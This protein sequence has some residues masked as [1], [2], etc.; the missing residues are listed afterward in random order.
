MPP[1]S[2]MAGLLGAETV[3]T[4]LDHWQTVR[5]ISFADHK[6][7]EYQIW[8]GLFGALCPIP[9]SLSCAVEVGPGPYG[10]LATCVKAD[11]WL[12]VDPLAESYADAGLRV[13]LPYSMWVTNWP[14]ERH[15]AD[16]VF[17]VNALDHATDWRAL[18]DKIVAAL[19][20]WRSVFYLMVHCRTA[21]EV[22]ELHPHVMKP[23]EI[24]AACWNTGLEV[25]ANREFRTAY[26]TL[27]LAASLA[28]V[29]RTR[30][31]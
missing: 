3:N 19:R 10:G 24:R 18:L 22:N 20:D 27:V 11:R 5:E 26:H 7:R 25:L 14:D 28:S 2:I 6:R 21:R 17:C 13:H 15:F 16:A 1:V 30:T 4:E 29:N 31:A 23:D 8:A 12:L 9:P